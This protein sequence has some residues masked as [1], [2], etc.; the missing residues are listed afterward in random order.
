LLELRSFDVCENATAPTIAMLGRSEID[1]EISDVG[2][3][4][5]DSD[6]CREMSRDDGDANGILAIM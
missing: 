3:E 1:I 2:M 6:D 4:T 5:T